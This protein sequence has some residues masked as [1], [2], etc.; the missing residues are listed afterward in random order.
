[1]LAGAPSHRVIATSASRVLH[2]DWSMAVSSTRKQ[3]NARNPSRRIRQR[4][5]R[6][7]RWLVLPLALGIAAIAFYIL[8]TRGPEGLVANEPPPLDDI[9]DASR[10]RLEHVIRDAE[11]AE[12]AGR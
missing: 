8:F 10:A 3:K 7:R 1:M 2:P 11:R 4:P 9:G 6:K 5:A 12:E